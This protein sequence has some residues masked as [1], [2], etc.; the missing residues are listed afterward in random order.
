MNTL[1]TSPSKAIALAI[2]LIVGFG[3][4]QTA[5]AISLHTAKQEGKVCEGPDG[6]L[7]AR[8]GSADV[9][10]LVDDVNS[11]RRAEYNRI[12]DQN[13]I[14][15]EAAAALAAGKLQDGHSCG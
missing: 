4:T 9:Q 2:T 3:Y 10:D 13:K 11:K 12:A 1:K 15:P 6:F 7:Q 5:C 14:T 8:D